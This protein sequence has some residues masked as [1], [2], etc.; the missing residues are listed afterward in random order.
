LTRLTGQDWE[1]INAK[2]DADPG[3]FGFPERRDNSVVLS[4]F[5]IRALGK[6]GNR[7]KHEW[8]FLKRYC[9]QCDLI[10]IQ[11]VKDDL[12][13][14]NELLRQLGHAYGMAASDITGGKPGNSATSAERLAFI[15][16]WEQVQRTEVASDLTFDRNSVLDS[17]YTKRDV[18][19]DDFGKRAHEIKNWEEKRDKCIADWKAAGKQD[20]KPKSPKKPPFVLSNFLTFIRTPYCTSFKIPGKP[21]SDP[22]EFLAINAHLLYGDKS[23]QKDERKMEFDALILWLLWRAIN[24]KHMYHKNILL[25]GDLNLDFEDV[26]DR[27]KDIEEYI[28]GLNLKELDSLESAKLNF[29]FL[30]I[31]PSRLHIPDPNKAIFR[32]TARLTQTYDQIAFVIDDKRIPNSNDNDTAGDPENPDGYNYGV[33]NFTELFSQAIHNRSYD[34]LSKEKKKALIKKYEHK[35]SDHLPIWVRLPLPE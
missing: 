23:L 21:G 31:H 17:I 11:E 3:K 25:F 33:F 6:K 24:V 10:G 5:N 22:Y 8:E 16:K 9:A 2:L 32:S 14:L 34:S 29:P 1:K 35:V 26:D 28:K 4:S 30:D 20:K 19:A 7:N 12:S 18:F 13:G 27:R 15:F